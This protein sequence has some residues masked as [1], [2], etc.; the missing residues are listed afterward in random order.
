MTKYKAP[1]VVLAAGAVLAL[2]SFVIFYGTPESPQCTWQTTKAQINASGCIG[3]ADIGRGLLFMLPFVIA[4]LTVFIAA[5]TALV[6]WY[7]RFGP[8]SK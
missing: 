8:P 6:V 2:T 1:L 5:I 4:G 3:G 7:R